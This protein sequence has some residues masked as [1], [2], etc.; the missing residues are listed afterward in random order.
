MWG[1]F[2]RIKGGKPSLVAGSTPV[3][4]PVLERLEPRILLSG[5]GLLYNAAPDPLLH[6]TQPL[7]QYAELLAA[8]EQAA[9]QPSPEQGIHQQADFFNQLDTDPWQP[10]QTLSAEVGSVADD[11]EPILPDL[12]SVDASNGAL[13]NTGFDE[14]GPM[15]PGE[16]LSGPVRSS[17]ADSEDTGTLTWAGEATVGSEVSMNDPTGLAGRILV[18]DQTDT[19]AH[20]QDEIS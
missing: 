6:I 4:P 1:I 3:M 13:G 20:I 15:Q 8:N 11:G 18:D 10:I 12:E 17:G 19:D 14:T 2:R 5:D 16:D 7:V 9:Q